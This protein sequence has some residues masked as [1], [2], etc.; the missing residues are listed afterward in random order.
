MAMSLDILHDRNIIA[1]P[2]KEQGL[3]WL[4]QNGPVVA[5]PP[6]PN[7][8]L[9]ALT[10]EERVL[11]VR[12]GVYV[13]PTNEGRLPSLPRVLSELADGGYITGY[14]AFG[15]HGLNDQEARQW[16]V[17]TPNRQ[18]DI[19]YGQREVHFVS[20][21]T[22]AALGQTVFVSIDGE[23]V[24]VATPAQA[25]VDEV[26]YAPFGIDYVA[27]TRVVVRAV[28]AGRIRAGDVADILEKAPS[29]SVARRVGFLLE[30]AGADGDLRLQAWANTHR[31]VTDADR[32]EVRNSRWHLALPQ[33]PDDI[34]RAAR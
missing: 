20:S 17:V 2:K 18:S 9:K 3:A 8:L 22:Q 19:R 1:L 27:L 4:V 24:R 10:D 11:R 29:S 16:W 26:R 21:P 34:R 31:A 14:A 30:L 28:T 5:D 15:L 32:F 7:W 13:A 33:S 6:L 12:R 25:L 23:S